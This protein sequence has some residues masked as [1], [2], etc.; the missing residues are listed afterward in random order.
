MTKDLSQILNNISDEERLML[1]HC[2]DMSDLARETRDDYSVDRESFCQ[3]MDINDDTYDSF[4]N[5]SYPY[6]ISD[7]A[8]LQAFLAELASQQKKRKNAVSTD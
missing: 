2:L 6:A 4:M 7:L 3:R 1:R 8:R 5:G